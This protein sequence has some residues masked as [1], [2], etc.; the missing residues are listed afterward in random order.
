MGG[1]AFGGRLTD[2]AAPCQLGPSRFAGVAAPEA[3]LDRRPCRR[4]LEQGRWVLIVGDLGRP[5]RGWAGVPTSR[6]IESA[7]K[8]PERLPSYCPVR[9][10]VC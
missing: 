1:G 3:V 5:R 7:R 2:P 9:A 4:A 10:V 8:G 6:G